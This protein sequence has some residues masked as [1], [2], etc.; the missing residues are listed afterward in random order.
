MKFR[1]CGQYGDTDAEYDDVDDDDDDDDGCK[2]PPL[3][4]V[5]R[6]GRR[7]HAGR[8]FGKD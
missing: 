4:W 6:A 8:R 5:G 2:V 7:D 3:T 1:C